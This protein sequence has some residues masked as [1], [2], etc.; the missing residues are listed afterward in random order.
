MTDYTSDDSTSDGPDRPRTLPDA[1]PLD[2]TTALAVMQVAIALVGA[3]LV[4]QGAG[5]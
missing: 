4:T 1:R 3:L 5:A 2:V